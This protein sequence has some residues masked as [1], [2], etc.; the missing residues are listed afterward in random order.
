MGAN[1]LSSNFLYLC[2]L[3]YFFLIF[4]ENESIGNQGKLFFI[5]PGTIM[6]AVIQIAFANT[7]FSILIS[8][9]QGNIVDTLMPRL[10]SLEL[11]LGLSIGGTIRGLII[12][13][14]S[15][16]LIFPLI[17]LRCENIFLFI[18]YILLASF[19][20]SLLGIM[21][22]IF[23]EKFDHLNGITNFIITPLAFLSGTFY[24][25]NVLPENLQKLCYLNPVFW[26]IDGASFG[27]LNFSDMNIFCGI[28][29]TLVFIFLLFTTNWILLFRGV[30]LKN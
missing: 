17:G 4:F 26:L 5:V 18:L 7:S 22:G 20:L 30:R 13:S 10:S 23:C 27:A 11:L 2:I 8:K 16:I 3:N 9:I 24:S 25:I 29:F 1:R 21:A 14:L 28:M 19:E 6:M 12:G 15:A